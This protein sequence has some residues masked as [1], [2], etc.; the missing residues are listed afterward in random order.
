MNRRSAFTLVEMLMTMTVGSSLML[1]AIGLVHQSLSMSKLAKTRGDHDR[2][3]AWLAQQ[4]RSDSH[5][6][7][8]LISVSSV[9]MSMKLVDESVVTYQ[10]NAP[11]VSREQSGPGRDTARESFRLD[12]ACIAAFASLDHP[13]RAVIQVERK[14]ANTEVPSPM[15]MRIVAVVGR[16][17][18]LVHSGGNEK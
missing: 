12:E 8:E 2:S 4:F 14:I 13:S 11:T 17:H 5:L 18:Q 15:D 10:W 9:G 7:S 1:L 16:W 6:T 3:L